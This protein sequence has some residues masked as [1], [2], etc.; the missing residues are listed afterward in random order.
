MKTLILDTSNQ[1]LLVA[2]Y[3][4]DQCVDCIQE[5]GS[6][7][8]SENCIPY[9]EKLLN[10]HNWEMMDLDEIVLTRG[11]GSYTGVRVAMTVAKTLSVISPVKIK[12]ISSLLAYAGL[13]KA[14]SILDARS[15]KIFICAYQDG[16]ALCEE[17]LIDLQ[18]LDAFLND[19]QG[20]EIVGQTELID[21]KEQEYNLAQNIYDASKHCEYVMNVDC[22]VPTYLKDVE[23]K[24]ICK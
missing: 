2:L 23:A 7:K 6:K 17:M 16:K 24:Q 4:D 12:A 14:V 21:S 13:K 9:I 20:F 3:Q 22:L 8:Q 15:K 5:L 11:P 18:D 10:K 19:Y 1:Y